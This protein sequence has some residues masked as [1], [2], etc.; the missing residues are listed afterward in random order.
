MKIFSF[1][2]MLL[3]LVSQST[4]ALSGDKARM[5]VPKIE[6]LSAYGNPLEYTVA[7]KVY[8]VLRS[9][10]GFRQAGVASWYGT[11]FHKKRTSS[12]EPYD[13]YA[14]TAAHKTLPI[15][16]YVRV[17]NVE[18]GREIIV[19][20]NDRGPFHSDRIIDLSYAAAKKLDMMEQGT[21]D[22]TLVSIV[23]EELEEQQHAHYYIQVAAYKTPAYANRLRDQIQTFLSSPVLVG[24]KGGHFVVFVGP[25]MDH[26][27]VT[28]AQKT[29]AQRG[30]KHTMTLIR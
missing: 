21:A 30:Y 27:M 8:R 20:V 29:L 26:Q 7:G 1:F 3:C 17:T 9:A 6:P 13:M 25:L 2:L 4:I 28:A 11:E 22:V 19:R 14:M 16:C 24:N 10:R 5:A 15:P 18:N 12:G 23:P